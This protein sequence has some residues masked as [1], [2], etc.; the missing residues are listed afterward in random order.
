MKNQEIADL[1]NHLADM[2]E[3]QG[4]LGFKVNAY[5]KASRVIFDLQEDIET[6]W[7]AKKLKELPGIGDALAK[8]IDEY[9]TTG[10]M[11]KYEEIQTQV[12][13]ELVQLL[14]I[15]NLGPKTLAL[16]HQQLGVKNL[17]DLK[18]SIETGRLAGLPGMGA[19]KVENIKKGIE[20]FESATTRISIGAARS[21]IDEIISALRQQVPLEKIEPAGSTRRGKETVGDLD[22]LAA[23]SD[24]PGVID[25]FVHLPLVERVLAAGDTKGSILVANGL[26]VD[27][28]AVPPEAFGAALQYFTGSQAHNIKLRGLARKQDLKINEYGIFRGEERIGGASEAEIYE[29]LGL[30]WIPPELREDRGEIEAAAQR[31]LPR[32]IE[33]HQIKGDLHVHS[34]YSDGLVSLAEMVTAAQRLGYAYLAF[35][36]HSKSAFYANGLSEARLVQ[37]MEEIQQLNPQFP[38]FRIFTGTE[39][40]ILPDGR[41]DFPDELLAQLD[42]V[43]AS[44]HSAFKQN[45]TERI[46][47]ALENPHVDIIGHPT[48][49]LISRREGYDVDLPK[50]FEVAAKTGTALEIN[51]YPDRLDLSD[52]HARSAIESGVRL[53]INTD[54]HEPGRLIDMQFGVATARRGWCTAANVLNTFTAEQVITWKNGRAPQ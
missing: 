23:T 26:Q 7:Q 3:L 41:L 37:Q 49:R 18:Q 53:V 16:A 28:R 44:I 29:Q 20:L 52:V 39:V 24:A 9:L 27:L 13:A 36:D 15:Q 21:I 31:R 54:A 48:G 5:R 47:A 8:K 38:G 2:L 11:Q 12:P 1:L 10:K 19:K 22:L 40:D 43:V 6:Y 50:I 42:I 51:A 34:N 32:L 17:T 4:E 35:C 45:P 25:A 14:Q 30:P 46:L 33:L